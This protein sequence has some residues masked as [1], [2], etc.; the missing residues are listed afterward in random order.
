M[1]W[2]STDLEVFYQ[3][4]EFID[5]LCIPLIPL[6]LANSADVH[7]L[8]NQK[9]SL[10]IISDE[11]ERN[12]TGRIMLSPTY[13]YVRGTDFQIECDRVNQWTSNLSGDHFQHIFLLSYD[14]NWK[15]FERDLAGSFVWLAAPSIDDFKSEHAQKAISNQTNQLSELIES[16][17]K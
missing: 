13:T 5:T 15:R 17:W 4:K 1:K 7:K 11:L 3:S 14:V 12:Y 8:A 6:D 2:T 10:Q 9:T 16:Y